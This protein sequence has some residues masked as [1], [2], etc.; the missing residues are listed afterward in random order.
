M[1][2]MGLGRNG[3]TIESAAWCE[4][5]GMIAPLW[6]AA[7]PTVPEID[8]SLTHSGLGH[9]VG[10]E[11]LLR[12]QHPELGVVAP[13]RFIGLAEESGLIVP[14]GA[15]VLRTACLQNKAWLFEPVVFETLSGRRLKDR[16]IVR[17][18][19]CHRSGRCGHARSVIS[20]AHSLRLRV[21]AEGVETQAQLAY[22]R[23]HGCDQMQGYYFSRPVGAEEFGQILKDGKNLSTELGSAASQRQTLLALDDS[24]LP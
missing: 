12:W 16:S 14:I 19:H 2:Q 23:R 8:C 17:A 4:R 21:I 11:A 18:R 1:D 22:L 6:C 9:I 20:M 10:M 15:W 5:P 3:R 7:A 13:M 24:V